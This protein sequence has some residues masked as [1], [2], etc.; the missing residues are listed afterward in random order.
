MKFIKANDFKTELVCYRIVSSTLHLR[1]EWGHA[2]GDGSARALVRPERPGPEAA[3]PWRSA[4]TVEVTAPTKGQT[5]PTQRQSGSQATI[6]P[7]TIQPA[8]AWN[9]LDLVPRWQDQ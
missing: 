7:N 5:A 3:R 1:R 4:P 6:D 9:S 2:A 8:P